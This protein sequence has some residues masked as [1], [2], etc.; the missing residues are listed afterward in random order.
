M[1][2]KNLTE[3][4]PTQAGRV[5]TSSSAGS[6]I[7]S[8]YTL[9]F[10]IVF[11]TSLGGAYN[12]EKKQQHGVNVYSQNSILLKLTKQAVQS[13]KTQKTHLVT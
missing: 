5:C 3:S 7:V 1:T 9:W 11:G 10:S 8:S 13:E 2:G 4:E 6:T 12:W